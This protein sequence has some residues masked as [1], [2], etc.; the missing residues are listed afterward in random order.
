MLRV[1]LID[2]DVPVACVV[3][4]LLIEGI[5]RAMLDEEVPRPA[6]FVN[7]GLPRPFAFTFAVAPT[8]AAF[9]VAPRCDDRGAIGATL[10]SLFAGVACL[11]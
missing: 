2:D 3:I 9:E 5:S 4:A 1:A 8:A 7:I 6:E 10:V 11:A